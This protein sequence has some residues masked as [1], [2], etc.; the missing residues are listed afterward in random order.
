MVTKNT[1]AGFV[2]HKWPIS[3]IKTKELDLIA[4]LKETLG[5]RIKLRFFLILKNLT[6]GVSTDLTIISRFFSISEFDSNFG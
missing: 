3:V 1:N 4:N 5:I 6:S 2:D